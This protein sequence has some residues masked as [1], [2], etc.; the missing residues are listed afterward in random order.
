[1]I[2]FRYHLVSLISVF[3]ALAIGIVLGA[4]PL[5]EP[6]GNSLNSQV[7]SLRQDRN[8]LQEKYDAARAEVS[9]RDQYLNQIKPMLINGVLNGQNV[10]LVLLPGAKDTDVKGLTDALREAGATITGSVSITDEWTNP[11]KAKYRDAL[12]GQIVQY[13]KTP[14]QAGASSG[15]ILAM[16]VA[17]LLT[18]GDDEI[19]RG[20]LSDSQGALFGV[21]SPLQKPAKGIVVVGPPPVEAPTSTESP[22]AEVQSNTN[23]ALLDLCNVLAGQSAGAVLVGAAQSGEDL[24]TLARASAATISTLDGV[25][26]NT[27][28]I[29][30]PLALASDMRGGRGDWGTAEGASTPLPPIPAKESPAQP[31]PS[32]SESPSQGS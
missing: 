8:I 21:N 23:Q 1:M 32:Q 18:H 30:L 31:E 16:A 29:S 7:D 28:A 26:K 13:L 19:L 17:Q 25:G 12:A 27:A 20:I 5:R 14:P 6:I 3:L 24:V 15:Q 22:T 11:E 4:G 2:D 9:E 10:D